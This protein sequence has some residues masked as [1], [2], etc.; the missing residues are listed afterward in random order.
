MIVG[1]DER[2]KVYAESDGT[3]SV[4]GFDDHETKIE[5]IEGTLPNKLDKKTTSGDYVYIHNGTTQNEKPYTIA[6]NAGT[7]AERTNT[8]T[9]RGATAVQD[10]DL[11]NLG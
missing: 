9:L 7:I 1:A 5:D 2:G 6:P 8:G 10:T 4:V 3:G 11:V